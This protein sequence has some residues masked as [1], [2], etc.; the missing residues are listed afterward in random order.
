MDSLND[1]SSWLLKRQRITLFSHIFSSVYTQRSKIQTQTKQYT[2]QVI[3]LFGGQ[4]ELEYLEIFY[5]SF[6][7]FEDIL[8]S[9][10]NPGLWDATL[11]FNTAVAHSRKDLVLPHPSP[12]RVALNLA[13]IRHTPWYKA[14]VTA[15]FRFHTDRWATTL[16]KN[17]LFKRTRH[18]FQNL[19]QN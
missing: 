5:V 18:I 13:L 11:H 4:E 17:A 10:K 3:W 8:T 7:S 12:L 9:V 16:K 15:S 19:F 6:L 2:G 14:V 1:A